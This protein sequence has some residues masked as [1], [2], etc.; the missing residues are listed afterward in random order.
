MPGSVT[1]VFGEPGDF[2]A[3]LREDGVLGMMITGRGR[4]RAR[5]TQITLH[6]HRLLVAEKH[7]PRIA[8]VA[9]PGDAALVLLPIGR[10]DQ[11]GAPPI[12]R[13]CAAPRTLNEAFHHCRR[14]EWRSL[15]CLVC[16]CTQAVAADSG[17]GRLL[18]SG[19][20]H[21]GARLYRSPLHAVRGR[22]TRCAATRSPARFSKPQFG[23]SQPAPMSANVAKSAFITSA[24]SQTVGHQR[25]VRC[26]TAIFVCFRAAVDGSDKIGC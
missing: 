24:I 25:P 14:T 23:Q 11:R 4:F 18:A 13:N 7:L 22:T 6:R 26:C 15:L 5:L 3:A 16:A 20:G 17:R 8:F 12:D 10:S 9:V 2:Q 19:V 1:S 21:L